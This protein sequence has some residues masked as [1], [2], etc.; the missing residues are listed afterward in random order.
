[1]KRDP[2]PALPPEPEPLPPQDVSTEVLLEKYAKGGERSAA[3]VLE[4]TARAL[5]RDESQARRFAD[6]MHDG[7]VPGGR[8][9]SA[10]GTGIQA[11]LINCFVQPVGDH[12]SGEHDGTPGIMRALEQAAETMRRGGGVGY[13]FSPIRPAGARVRGTMSRASGPVSYMRVFD[14]MCK[15]VESAGARRG[16]QMG[17]LRCDHP[18]I[19]TFVAAKRT[20]G[21]LTQFNVSVAV[22]DALMRAVEADGEFELVHAAEPSEAI[23]GAWRR[24]DG[25]WVYRRVRARALWDAIMR[26]AYDYAEPGVLFIDTINARNNLSYCE[27]IAATNPCGEQSLPAY[28]CCDLGSVDLTRVVRRPFEPDAEIDWD[29]LKRL[30]HT[31]V[32]ILDRVLDVTLWPLPQQ[33]AEARA[34]RRIGLGFLGLGDALILLGLRYDAEAGREM[35]SRIS[36]F[37][38]HEAYRASVGL[39]KIHGPFPLFDAA[40]Y[41]AAPR[42]ASTLPED[43]KAEIARHGVRNSHLLSIAPTGTITLAFADN[44]SNGIEPAFSWAYTRMKRMADG[45][46]QPFRVFDHAFRLWRT[47]QPDPEAF[48]AAFDAGTAALPEAFV[49]ALEMSAQAH[50]H[51]VAAVAPYVDAAISKTVNVP[52]DA[53]RDETASLYLDA[54]KLG[55]KGI[56]IY[57]PNDVTG[58][59]LSVDAPPASRLAPDDLQQSDAD[60]RIALKQIPAPALASLRWPDRP[61]LPGG[62]P[63]WTLLV[64]HPAGDFAVVV[65]HVEQAGRARPFEV[66]VTGNEQPRG[67][68]AIAKTLSMDLRCDDPAWVAKKLDSLAATAGQD[69]FPIELEPGRVEAMPSLVAGLA[70]I[71]RHRC[72]TLGLFAEPP[73]ATPMLDALISR[74]EPKT[75]TDGTMSWS[76][77]VANPATGDDIHMIVKE[78]TLPDGTRRPYSVWLAGTYPRVFDGLTKLLS[79]DM[80]IV[81][82]A[83][84][85]RKLAKLV[86]FAE[87]RGDFW[88]PVPGEAKSRVW[89]STLA[90]LARLLLHRY[91]MLG[92]LDADGLPLVPMH[93]FAPVAGDATDGAPDDGRPRTR[94]EA[95]RVTGRVCPECH[96]PTLAKVDGCDRCGT[97]G[98]I[99]TCG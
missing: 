34:K 11:T 15:T 55:L 24:D 85:G 5:A 52:A 10:A 61:A 2:H 77:D 36:R 40:E 33:D 81:D 59:V 37:M 16:A 53:A 29:H 8:I 27:S 28:G 31:G 43:L 84:I 58:A 83:W 87:P 67:L 35:A 45:S 54:W 21:E 82:T 26:S 6:A 13:D 80:R 60:R 48:D 73:S 42:F 93:A 3:E 95:P 20:P 39:A 99:G 41:L 38:A 23:E 66:W 44:A 4:R 7:F 12:M 97:C 63:S 32:E 96:H 72:E 94:P 91:Q 92:I 78:L 88:A 9:A 18:D 74:K 46:R 17:V 86:D 68:A 75:G 71:V 79:I 25:Q 19:E 57:R 50:L 62:N 22:T 47:R 1:M 14:A 51:M 64:E 98:W 49:S 69:G 65:G 70:R 89:P 76:V 30:V 56:T 90:Y